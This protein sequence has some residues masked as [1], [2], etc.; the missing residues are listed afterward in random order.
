MDWSRITDPD[1]GH[2]TPGGS[3]WYRC[4]LPHRALV[5]AGVDSV[6]G[7]LVFSQP[8]GRF[9]VREW[10]GTDHFDVNPVVLQRWMLQ[11]LPE[12]IK[13]ARSNGQLVVNDV[14]D[15]FFGMATQNLASRS[16]NSDPRSNLGHYRKILAAADFVIAST[17]YLAARL[18]SF[19][20]DVRIV[21]NHIDLDRWPHMPQRDRPILG[22]A[23]ALPWRSGDLETLTGTL[24]SLAAKLGIAF[25][26]SGHIGGDWPTAYEVVGLDPADPLHSN[27]PMAPV[28]EWP[29]QF[30]HFDVGIV[31][32]SPRPF[33]EAKSAIKGM[34][35]VAAGKP[36]V[37]ADTPE[38]RWLAD[39][40]V[41]RIARRPRDWTRH[42]EVLLTMSA[43]ERQAEA[44]LNRQR[45]EDA[46]LTTAHLAEHWLG[47]V[48]S[49]LTPA[50]SPPGSPP[51][52]RR[53]AA[54]PSRSGSPSRSR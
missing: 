43:E 39:Q 26:H 1:T 38:Y 12:D 36:F 42:L 45:L 28:T 14:D 17:P 48:V 29:D 13:V 5:A 4:H 9:A 44:D 19:L 46:H 34:E 8:H 3:G 15:W 18:R 25:H 47:A 27:T 21:R 50:I 52:R 31:P 54:G 33:N 30:V 37:A 35:Y 23:G 24:P 11:E 41:G 10:D 49:D 53:P 32:L 51:H 22:W 20:P 2:P 6:I 16:L 40:G 7:R